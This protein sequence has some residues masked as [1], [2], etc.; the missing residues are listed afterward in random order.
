MHK[1]M[2]L[3]IIP[4]TGKDLKTTDGFRPITKINCLGKI[5]EYFISMEIEAELSIFK[6][7]LSDRQFGF[8]KGI[9]SEE[10][11]L[12]L[13]NR[14]RHIRA[15]KILRACIA[16]DIKGALDYLSHHSIIKAMKVKG[17]NY[18]L[19]AIVGDFLSNRSCS[20]M[21]QEREL[22]RGCP[23]GSVL[24]PLLWNLAFDMFLDKLEEAG[25]W[26]WKIANSW[27]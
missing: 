11:I 3:T 8:R 22:G 19:I 21:D 1:E 17:I 10:D 15:N 24:G 20:F 23:Q 7:N 4:N 25:L 18:N 9:S 13:D 2:D 14:L 5:L 27:K 26:H 16:I 6:N 12:L